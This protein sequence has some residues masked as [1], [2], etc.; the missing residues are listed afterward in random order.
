MFLAGLLVVGQMNFWGNYIP[1]VFPVHLRGTGETVAANIGGR[2]IG[3]AAAFLTITFSASRPA[4]PAKMA[5][6]AAAVALAPT[7]P[8]GYAA[9]TH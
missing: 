8:G 1:L 7:P 6:A 3:T 4:N 9:V 5:L 2:V